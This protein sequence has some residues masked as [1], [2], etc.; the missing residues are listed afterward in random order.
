MALF[1]RRLSVERLDARRMFASLA[2]DSPDGTDAGQLVSVSSSQQQMQS[3]GLEHHEKPGAAPVDGLRDELIEQIAHSVAADNLSGARAA[4]LRLDFA[5]DR[6]EIDPASL[7]LGDAWRG[8]ASL[9]KKVDDELG[10]I[11]VFIFSAQPMGIPEGEMLEFTATMHDGATAG[12]SQSLVE[13]VKFELNEGLLDTVPSMSLDLTTSDGR[14]IELPSYIPANFIVPDVGIVGYDELG[15][16]D[17]EPNRLH[18]LHTQ[19]GQWSEPIT[20]RVGRDDNAATS[21]NRKIGRYRNWATPHI[22]MNHWM[23][24][25]IES[26]SSAA[27]EGTTSLNSMQNRWGRWSK[28]SSSRPESSSELSSKPAVAAATPSEL[29]HSSEL[30]LQLT[31]VVQ[32]CGPWW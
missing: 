12:E 21:I 27:E 32:A 29:N 4:E 11:S 17:G 5:S 1:S 23:A 2:Y 19:P 3:S 28:V 30:G 8:R 15:G 22:F 10:S 18:F 20:E 9:V 13:L 25:R 7:K 26:P 24:S 6:M 14:L 16:L 31:T